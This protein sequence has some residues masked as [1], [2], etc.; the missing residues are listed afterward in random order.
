MIKNESEYADALIIVE[1][2]MDSNP[3]KGTQQAQKLELLTLL[4]KEYESSRYFQTSVSD[5]VD[6]IQFRMEQENLRQRDLVKYIGSRS[7][8]SEILSRKRDLSLSMIRALN[9][10]L[11]IPLKS[12]VS[13]AKS[14]FNDPDTFEWG[15]FPVKEMIK[16]NWIESENLQSDEDIKTAVK[17]FFSKVGNPE[18]F[19]VFHRKTE[20]VRS[21]KKFDQYALSAWTARILSLAE[22]MKI[23]NKYQSKNFT[24]DFIQE[25]VQMSTR[26]HAPVLIQNILMDYGIALVIEPQLPRT[27]LDGAALLHKEK[28]IIGMTLRYDRLDNFWFTLVHEL[29]HLHLHLKNDGLSFYDDLDIDNTKDDL[30]E[31]ADLFA[32]EILIPKNEWTNSPASKLRTPQAAQHLANKLKIDPAIIVGRMRYKSNNYRILNN[33]VG[34]KEVRK[35]FP[36]INWG[37]K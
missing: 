29:A 16:R 4:I 32:S 12:L 34:H 8:V 36:G 22:N 19:V 9:K 20:H 1:N 21:A 28:P 11:G 25:L 24:R 26:D 27:H 17:H 23:T 14:G 18:Q 30:E 10:G 5:P 7:K 37:T 2:L 13:E 15:R 31:E 35:C 6:A 3:E 33:L